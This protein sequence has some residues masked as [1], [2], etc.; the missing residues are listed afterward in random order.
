MRKSEFDPTI[1][2]R[3]GWILIAVSVAAPLAMDLALWLWRSL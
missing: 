1:S 2:E 3:T